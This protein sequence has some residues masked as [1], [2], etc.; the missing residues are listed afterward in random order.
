MR[1]TLAFNELNSSNKVLSEYPR[2][3]NESLSSISFK[4]NDIE[5]MIKNL[6]PNKSYGHDLLCICMLKLC[7]ESIY[8]PLNLLF[9]S[10]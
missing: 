6:D 1:E 9:K 10:F 2:K 7:V 3:S 4:I 5:K 8:K